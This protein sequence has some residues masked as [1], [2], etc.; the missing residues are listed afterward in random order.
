[1]ERP[2]RPSPLTRCTRVHS[3][4]RTRP[5]PG[6]ILN[7]AFHFTTLIGGHPFQDATNAPAPEGSRAVSAPGLATRPAIRR[8]PAFNA[9]AA[10]LRNALSAAAAAGA[11]P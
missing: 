9:G 11:D 10:E 4:S 2:A 1:M 5:P 7:N 8:R 3:P 6:A